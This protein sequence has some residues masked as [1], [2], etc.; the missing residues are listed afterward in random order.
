MLPTSTEALPTVMFSSLADCQ[1]KPESSILGPQ[2]AGMGA[3]KETGTVSGDSW[4]S[5]ARKKHVHRWGQARRL[6]PASRCKEG[7]APQS[8]HLLVT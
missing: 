6:S 8:W 4:P 3:A 1:G 7:F 2:P 5:G